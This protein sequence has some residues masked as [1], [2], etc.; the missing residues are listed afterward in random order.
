M[1]LIFIVLMIL[2][3]LAVALVAVL[4]SEI[5]TVNYLIG[6]AE[7]TLFAVILGSALAGVVVM[8][9]F[10]IYRSIHGYVKSESERNLKR[11]MQNRIKHLEKENKRL[12]DELSKLQKER[13]TAA[14]QDRDE[15]EAEKRRLE[16]ELKRE[17]KAREESALKEQDELESEKEK[18]EKELR[19]QAQESNTPEPEG[20]TEKPPEKKGFFDFLKR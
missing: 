10:I 12:E 8:V 14:R 6:Q 5:V 16:E 11:E 7:L 15:L 20:D 17:R 1:R 19:K 4:N 2:V 3:A 9:F 18:L 13:E